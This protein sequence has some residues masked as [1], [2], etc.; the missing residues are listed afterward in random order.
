MAGSVGES[1]PKSFAWGVGLLVVAL[2]LACAPKQIVP[3]QVGPG[4]V[5]VFVDGEPLPEPPPDTLDLKANRGHVVF[6]KK[7]GHRAQQVILRSVDQPS[8]PPALEPAQIV[9]ELRP[10]TPKGR[11]LEVELDDGGQAAPASPE[12][13][14]AP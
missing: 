7:D 8:G 10:A 2:A 6:V 14:A 3:L 9:V 5:Q 11:R 1:M 12:A 4:V 13:Q